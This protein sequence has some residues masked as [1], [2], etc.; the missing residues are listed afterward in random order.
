MVI[1]VYQ[2]FYCFMLTL[3]F[4]GQPC[5]DSFK[6]LL[7]SSAHGNKIHAVKGAQLMWLVILH[8]ARV[9]L[10]MSAGLASHL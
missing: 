4:F 3:S 6:A 2:A 10:T 9:R 5:G 7:L 1:H 8:L